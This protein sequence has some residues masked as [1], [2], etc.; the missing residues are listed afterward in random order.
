MRVPASLLITGVM[1][2]AGVLSGVGDIY[3][4]APFGELRDE[5]IVLASKGFIVRYESPHTLSFW[6]RRTKRPACTARCGTSRSVT[7]SCLAG[8]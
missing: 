4:P 3:A 7:S 1:N 6:A 2:R 8:S 5:M